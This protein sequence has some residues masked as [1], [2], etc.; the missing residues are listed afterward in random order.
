MQVLADMFVAKAR[1]AQQCG[2]V[3]GSAGY[4]HGFAG[5]GNAMPTFRDSLDASHVA[6]VNTNFMSTRF[7]NDAG[8]IFL[9]IGNP[10]SCYGFFCASGASAPAVAANFSLVAAHHVARHS[11]N[12]P[13]QRA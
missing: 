4:H 2:S 5:N 1:T 10:R 6:G 3:N 13:A 9:S 12:V 8:T 11:V 7:G